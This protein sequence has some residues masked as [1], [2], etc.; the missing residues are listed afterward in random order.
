[1]AARDDEGVGEF[2]QEKRKPK[3][4]GKTFCSCFQYWHSKR[5]WKEQPQR[6]EL[7]VKTE[8]SWGYRV[9]LCIWNH[10]P[11]FNP[12]IICTVCQ[13]RWKL[14]SAGPLIREFPYCI[15]LLTAMGFW[16]V[17]IHIPGPHSKP[18]IRTSGVKPRGLGVG[19]WGLCVSI[20]S[21]GDSAG[22]VRT[23][24]KCFV[25][26]DVTLWPLP[27][28]SWDSFKKYLVRSKLGCSNLK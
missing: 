7:Q 3:E 13:R 25:G 26:W 27:T 11:V 20:S 10:F 28:P 17:E 12:L 21:T 19:G 14:R 16:Q 5:A 1:M 22:P 23:E 6:V 4:E 8:D 9:K 15:G 24:N 2:A 18:K